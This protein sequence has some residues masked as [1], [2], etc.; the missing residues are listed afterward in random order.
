MQHYPV[1]LQ[2]I[3]VTH[4]AL[5]LRSLGWWTA[6]ATLPLV[7]VAVSMYIHLEPAQWFSMSAAA[8]RGAFRDALLYLAA[9][10][11]LVA[12]LAGVASVTQRR[13]VSSKSSNGVAFV[14]ATGRKLSLS[15]IVFVAV[16]ALMTAAAAGLHEDAMLLLLSSHTTLAA[17]GVALAAFGALCGVALSDSLDAAACSL[18]TVLTAS[19][20]VFVS[21]PWAL[22]APRPLLQAAL[23]ANPFVTI[24]TASQIDVARMS[25]PYQ[26]SALAHVQVLYPAWTTACAWY[27]GGAGICLAGLGGMIH[28]RAV[29]TAQGKDC[30]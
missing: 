30:S 16:S 28:T 17:V 12:P 23:T 14:L 27:A 4:R 10:V 3:S 26:L 2:R 6:A 13:A 22:D 21:G 5:G 20:A 19:L 15:V 11:I 8:R 1:S 24:A 18:L 29:T 9:T 7:A 25:V